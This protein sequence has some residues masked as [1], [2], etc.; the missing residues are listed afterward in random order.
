VVIDA[1]Q[2]RAGVVTGITTEMVEFLPGRLEPLASNFGT[3]IFAFG[4]ARPIGAEIEGIGENAIPLR[5]NIQIRPGKLEIIVLSIGFSMP[6]RFAI[7]WGAGN[8]LQV[9]VRNVRVGGGVFGQ[10]RATIGRLNQI[11]MIRRRGDTAVE[12]RG[13][14]PPSLVE[15]RA[16]T[17]GQV[18]LA[19][20]ETSIGLTCQIH[21][22]FLQEN[23]FYR[24]VAAFYF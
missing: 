8:H 23:L 11:T 20:T 14:V 21:L 7:T 3:R 1:Q 4:Y 9:S 13:V 15:Q 2:R 18:S 16:A 6:K 17:P 22:N 10:L 24:A 19:M 5:R 12:L